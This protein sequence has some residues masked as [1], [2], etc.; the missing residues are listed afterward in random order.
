MPK[1]YGNTDR[2][3]LTT[4]LISDRK[5][6]QPPARMRSYTE[7]ERKSIRDSNLIY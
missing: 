5:P 4:R 2:T 1:I 3:T 6:E 7:V